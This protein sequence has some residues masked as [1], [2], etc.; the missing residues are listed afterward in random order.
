MREDFCIRLFEQM[1]KLDTIKSQ[2]GCYLQT[3]NQ[4]NNSFTILI[5]EFC[6][7]SVS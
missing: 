1:M 4:I 3:R 5:N 7:E 2:N 6:I